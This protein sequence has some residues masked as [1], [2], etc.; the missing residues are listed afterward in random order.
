MIFHSVG[1][2]TN[3]R[4]CPGKQIA[5]DMLANILVELGKVRR[6]DGMIIRN[7]PT[8]FKLHKE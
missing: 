6:A 4:I 3:G 1:D 8:D 5:M 2:R 7:L